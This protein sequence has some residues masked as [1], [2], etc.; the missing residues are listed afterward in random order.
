MKAGAAGGIETGIRV[1][2]AHIGNTDVCC[3][4]CGALRSMML[5]NGKNN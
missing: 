4:G 1:I 5:G 3:V 2:N